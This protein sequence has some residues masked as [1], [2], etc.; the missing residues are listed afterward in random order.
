MDSLR[1]TARLAGL[2]Y[3]LVALMTPFV[4]LY[5]P[6]QLEAPGDASATVAK[7]AANQGLFIAAILVGL[8]SQVFFVVVVLALY[9]LL[10]GVDAQLAGL[11]AAFILLQ[12]P[13]AF[14]GL[15]HDVAT[16]QFIR[17]G[18]FLDVFDPPHRDALALLMVNVDRQGVL[19][20]QVSWGLWLLP[21]GVLVIR[22]G[23]LPRV[24][25]FWLL[26]NGLAY[27]ALSG[28]GIV[29]PEYRAAAFNWSMPFMFGELALA[30]WLLVMGIRLE[31]PPGPGT[32]LTVA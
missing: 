10:R 29:A 9:R 27:L 3:V 11:M 30:L 31:S 1:G 5:V 17:G 26:L 12:A 22:S 21:L 7:I 13:V 19:V 25:G 24:L 4:L 23:F 28:I 20:S 6:G 18:Q 32:G 15:S 14:L 2:L 8:V 16:L